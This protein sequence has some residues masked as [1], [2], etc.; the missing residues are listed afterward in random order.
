M[1]SSAIQPG[2]ATV[3]CMKWGA[4]YGASYVNRLRLMVRRYLAR[5]HRFLCFTEQPLG[6]DP[7]I[8]IR[9]LPAVTVPPGPERGWRKLGIL[10]QKQTG[11]EGPTLF[12]DLDIV[13]MDSIDC[14]FDLPGDFCIIRDWL[15]GHR[16]VGNSSVFRFLPGRHDGV[17]RQFHAK[18]GEVLARFRNEQEYLSASAGELTWWPEEWCRSFKRHCMHP[19]PVS[20]FRTPQRPAEVRILVHHGF[21]KPEEALRGSCRSLGLRY[22]RPTPW[23][24]QYLDLEARGS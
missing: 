14:F 17:L 15:R 13:I 6:I 12:L 9:K 23:L 19:F 20:L 22:T 7:D 3:V 18:T 5:P 24:A 8:E 4:K 21:P 2:A 11:L 10:D 1:G 16:N